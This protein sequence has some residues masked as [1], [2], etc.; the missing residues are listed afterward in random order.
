MAPPLSLLRHSDV[1]PMSDNSGVQYQRAGIDETLA[2]F[3]INGKVVNFTKGPA[4]TQF[5]IK[6]EPGVRVQSVANI[7]QN[8]QA[9]IAAKTI[10][11]QAPIPG[12]ST[13]GPLHFDAEDQHAA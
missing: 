13:I 12:K 5:E 2:E 10:R 4:V 6:L 1:K 11:V 7:A 9:K 3:N 8:I